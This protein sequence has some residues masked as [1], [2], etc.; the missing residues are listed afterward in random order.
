MFIP[1]SIANP[2]TKIRIP[3]LLSH[4]GD[5][6]VRSGDSVEPTQI[7]AQAVTPPDFRIVEVAQDL[8]LPAQKAMAH[9]K[10]ERGDSVSQGDVVAARGGLGTRVSR[11]PIAGRVVGVGRGRLLLEGEPEIY[12]LNALVPGYVTEAR[13]EEG[14]VIELVG[15]FIQ[16]LW[17]NGQEA[18]GLLR[19]LVREAQHPIR[20]THINASSQGAIL[21]GG[22][23]V[24]EACI[25]QAEEM[26][27]RGIVVGSIPPSL[28]ERAKKAKLAL[29]ATEGIGSTPMSATVFELLR[30][31]DGREAA[32]SGDIGDRWRPKRPFI[33]VPMPTRAAPSVDIDAP[34]SVGD[35]VRILRGPERGRSGTVSQMLEGL[36][37]LDTGARLRGVEVALGE[38]EFARVPYANIERL[39]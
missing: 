20:P 15:G 12:R 33:V 27:V 26:Q 3:R 36:I 8:D 19:L 18:Y 2:L 24:D 10:V 11:S 32:V 7:V 16:A 23:T 5:V 17:G 38:D 9:L 25:D 34:L 22:S 37:Q 35:R 6:L 21:I 30:S 14:V 13:P 4:S 29:I 39:L 1:Y 28:L 31:V